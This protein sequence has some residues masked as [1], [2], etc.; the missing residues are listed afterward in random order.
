[1]Q[2]D[3]LA[4][5]TQPTHSLGSPEFKHGTFEADEPLRPGGNSLVKY[6][7]QRQILNRST[8]AI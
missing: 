6:N 8:C 7:W 4:V 1:M 3:Q 2:V 5:A